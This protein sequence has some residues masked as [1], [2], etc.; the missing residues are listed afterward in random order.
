MGWRP[1]VW[2][3]FADDLGLLGAALPECVGGFGGGAV[4]TMLISEEF[5]RVLVLEPYL[6]SV[7]LGPALLEGHDELMAKV[8]DGSAILA[9]AL[10]ERAGR[11]NLARVATTAR[12]DAR[13]DGEKVAVAAAPFAT[14][15]IVSARE[16]DALSLFLID[17]AATGI[18]RRDYALIDGRI[19][20]DLTFAGTAASRIGG[21]GDALPRIERAVDAAIAALCAEAVGVM[22]A[23][24]DATVIYARQREQFG[25]AIGSFQVLQHRMVDMLTHLERA[26]S[27]TIMATL[28]LDLEPAGRRMAVSAAKAFVS[29]ALKMVGEAAIQIHGGIGT[30]EE[31]AISHYFKRATV[32]Q[33]QFGTA[34]YHL[35]RMAAA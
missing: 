14:H 18:E 2:R 22:A 29:K 30:T 28:S 17:A 20:A 16:G 1:E 35:D 11:F 21:A 12:P 25:V 7:V 4:E 9:P 10:Y 15:Y 34:A 31:I 32:M 24:L 13:L 3:G 6:E 27:M 26:R 23:M 5:G 33:S 8:I 19:A